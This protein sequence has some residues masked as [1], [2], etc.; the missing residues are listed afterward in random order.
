MPFLSPYCA[1][2][3]AL[4]CFGICLRQEMKIL[5]RLSNCNIQVTLIEPG[6][7]ATGFN[8][9]N[10]NKKYKW[11]YTDSYFSNYCSFIRKFEI[12]IWNFLEQKPYK[13]ITKNI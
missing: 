5:K 9:E 7:Y 13:S 8:K 4:E 6:A 3:F 2:K 1:S 10:N 12:K 11:M